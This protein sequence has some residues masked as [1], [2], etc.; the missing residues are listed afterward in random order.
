VS[1][2][3]PKR[4]E[5]ASVLTASRM[6][7]HAFPS[8]FVSS[9]REFSENCVYKHGGLNYFIEYLHRK[10]ALLPIFSLL[11]LKVLKKSALDL[12]IK[13]MNFLFYNYMFVC[14]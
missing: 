14:I 13:T 3:W 10:F 9:L 11:I 7:L 1:Q 4:A 8:M 6:L 5:K 12:H 2:E